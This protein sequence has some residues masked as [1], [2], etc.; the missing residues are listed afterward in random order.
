MFLI[1][2]SSPVVAAE[3]C[4][5]CKTLMEVGP[6]PMMD[7]SDSL[8]LLVTPLVPCRHNQAPAGVPQE[9]DLY[10]FENCA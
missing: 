4:K 9:Y 6:P 1:I 3:P 2:D 7:G 8:D 5:T 10:R